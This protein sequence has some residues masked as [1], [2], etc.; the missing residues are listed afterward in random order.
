M[1]KNTASDIFTKKAKEKKIRPRFRPPT[2]IKIKSTYTENMLHTTRYPIFEADEKKHKK[3]II[4]LNR[5]FTE[6]LDLQENSVRQCFC[7][8]HK[9]QNPPQLMGSSLKPHFP[10]PDS[11]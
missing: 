7:K 4:R 1:N 9:D 2:T 5:L 11:H 3:W 10:L 8:F 6:K